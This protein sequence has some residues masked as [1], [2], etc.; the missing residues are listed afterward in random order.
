[1]RAPPESLNP[2]KG[3]PALRAMSMTL[4]I[5]LACISPRLPARA[6][7]SCAKAK[8]SRP[9]TLPKPVMTPSAGISTLSMPNKVPL[10]F[11]NMSISRKVP[12]SKKR[13]RRARA[14]IL[15][16]SSCAATALG[17]PISLIFAS[18]SRRSLILSAT[19]PISASPP[20]QDFDILLV[21]FHSTESCPF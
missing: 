1:M 11:T 13:S 16:R 21:G 6:V 19:I 17:P 3:F 12:G 5:F 10:C 15:P 4:V 14:V 2:T 8:T 20:F 18:R 9:F 7:K